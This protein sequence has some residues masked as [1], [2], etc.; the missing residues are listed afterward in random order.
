MSYIDKQIMKI[1]IS[2][3]PYKRN[4]IIAG[5]ALL[6]ILAAGLFLSCYVYFLNL[7][8][9]IVIN[10]FIAAM[11]V[12]T[13]GIISYLFVFSSR[14]KR[15][16]SVLN[17]IAVKI[18]CPDINSNP[19]NNNAYR[20]IAFED[21]LKETEI[22]IMNYQN[23]IESTGTQAA[24]LVDAIEK[25]SDVLS[26]L[27]QKANEHSKSAEIDLKTAEQIS[28]MTIEIVD[29][30]EEQHVS[31]GLLV[32]RM[33]DF[34]KIIESISVELTKQVNVVDS[35]SESFSSGNEYLLQMRQSM[36]QISAS[37]AKM[38]D[39]LKLITKI[40]DQINL[41]S[42]NAAIE[43]ARAGEHGL[44]FAVVSNEISKLAELTASSIKEIDG[45]IS[46]NEKEIKNGLSHAGRTVE[47][48]ST[49]LLGVSSVK[50]M[51]HS[52]YEKMTFQIKN[53]YIVNEE[54]DK[55]RNGTSA[56]KSAIEK[57]KSAI[58]GLVA[59]IGNMREMSNYFSF[60]TAKIVTNVAEIS[61]GIGNIIQTVKFKK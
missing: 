40:S 42:L 23:L 15:L 55:V 43:S 61:E 50:E 28:S 27:S 33:L 16:I 51:M 45:L 7:S 2:L 56:I 53:N 14:I 57:Q 9:K 32:A 37:S 1:K 8:V 58:D 31:L 48:I 17:N 24:Q 19:E 47:T 18:Y 25:N 10:Y 26:F 6:L 41:L 36:E 12:S 39:S 4:A 21:L 20:S 29:G 3:N 35:I 38:A 54:S 30:A 13:G 60:L 46:K 34:T 59:S 52:A 5:T 49:V 22:V 11:V 44:G